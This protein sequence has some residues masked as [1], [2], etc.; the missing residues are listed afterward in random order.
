MT[1]NSVCRIVQGFNW[2]FQRSPGGILVS[3]II[4]L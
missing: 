2:H 3:N 4:H 1:L